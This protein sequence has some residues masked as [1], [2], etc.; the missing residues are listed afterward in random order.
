MTHGMRT[1]M[2]A[3][4]TYTAH[5]KLD[6]RTSNHLGTKKADKKK[7]HRFVRRKEKI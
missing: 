2:N 1:H 3:I 5:K 4:K 6:I 7:S